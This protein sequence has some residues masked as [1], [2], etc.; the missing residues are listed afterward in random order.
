VLDQSMD[1]GTEEDIRAVAELLL[2]FMD[3][4]RREATRYMSPDARSKDLLQ[5]AYEVRLSS[6]SDPDRRE[7]VRVLRQMADRA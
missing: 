1:V 2:S 7:L 3:Q 4:I 5:W 6:L